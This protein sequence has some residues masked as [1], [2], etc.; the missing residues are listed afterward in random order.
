MN[1]DEVIS[2]VA[3]TALG[4]LDFVFPAA[5]PIISIAKTA[6][7]AIIAAAPFVKKAFNDGV[8]A[9]EAADKASPGLG[10]M[11][12]DMLHHGQVAS[13]PA[14][15]AAHHTAHAAPHPVHVENF[16]R[17]VFGLPRMTNEEE[18]NW[19]DRATPLT[20]QDSRYGGG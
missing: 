2:G 17:S 14:G 11:L 12:V 1:T 9:I 18:A 10:G 16:A 4:I 7:P 13:A 15:N 8:S 20:D 19:M 6:V 5:G 3:N